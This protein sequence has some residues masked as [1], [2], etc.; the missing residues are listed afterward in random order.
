MLSSP[1]ALHRTAVA[2]Y[3]GVM[4]LLVLWITWLSPPR[5]EFISLAL[6][7]LLGPLLFPLRGLLHARRYT[8]AWSTMLILLYFV[9]G[10]ASMASPGPGRWLGLLEVVLVVIY[11]TTCILYIRATGSRR[12]GKR[13]S[14]E[15]P[16]DQTQGDQTQGDQV[17]GTKTRTAETRGNESRDR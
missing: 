9:H 3:L 7:A 14:G 12:A 16:T 5:P 6:I 13:P 2:S 1:R 10:V 11:F 4:A 17:R 8:M 15:A